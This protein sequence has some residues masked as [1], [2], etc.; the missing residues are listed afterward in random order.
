MTD[1]RTLDGL[2]TIRNK[3][4]TGTLMNKFSLVNETEAGAAWESIEAGHGMVAVDRDWA[5]SQ[6]L[7]DTESH[8]GD[9]NK[10][11]YVMEA[12]HNMHC[13]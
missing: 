9:S 7:P 5:A 1:R 3:A 13:L 6:S 10:A 4:R 8:P 11:V 12:Y 2:S